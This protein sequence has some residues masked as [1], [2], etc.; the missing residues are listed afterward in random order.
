MI[1][2]IK[3]F[4]IPVILVTTPELGTINH[5]LLTIEAL[6]KRNID[7]AGIIFNKMPQFPSVIQ[8]DN[9]TIIETVSKVP[10]IGIIHDISGQIEEKLRTEFANTDLCSIAS[11][12]KSSLP[13]MP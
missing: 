8:Q 7:I 9:I 4:D 12:A 3:D 13:K 10:V 5:T 11:S 2:L 6:K 1:D